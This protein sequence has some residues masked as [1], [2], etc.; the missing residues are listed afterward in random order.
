VLCVSLEGTEETLRDI[1]FEVVVPAQPFLP[2]CATSAAER[3]LLELETTTI[4]LRSH[5]SSSNI[6]IN[7]KCPEEK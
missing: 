3:P 6:F 2:I 1:S 4:S 7:P 5:F